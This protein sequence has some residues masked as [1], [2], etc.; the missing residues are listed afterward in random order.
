LEPG[1]DDIDPR[2]G[3][4]LEEFENSQSW[5]KNDFVVEEPRLLPGQRMRAKPG[6]GSS[7]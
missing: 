4:L 5:G 1:L 6:F 3:E 2:T 7:R